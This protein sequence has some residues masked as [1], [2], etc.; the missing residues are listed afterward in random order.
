[1]L[2][3]KII[4]LE[5]SLL[6]LAKQKLKGKKETQVILTQLEANCQTHQETLTRKSKE[7][8]KLRL[9]VVSLQGQ[10]KAKEK[11]KPDKFPAKTEPINP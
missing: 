11:P 10:L 6:S 8:S 9:E 7:L 4:D 5:Q 1:L 2:E 3:Q